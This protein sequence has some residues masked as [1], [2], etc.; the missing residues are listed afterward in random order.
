MVKLKRGL[1]LMEAVRLS[2]NSSSLTNG[3]EC[4]SGCTPYIWGVTAGSTARSFGLLISQIRE[5][6]AT[7]LHP[8]G[9][10]DRVSHAAVE[11]EGI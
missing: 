9:R 8:D 1:I 2:L 3:Y 5:L 7:C 10:C 11:L 6:R 4:C